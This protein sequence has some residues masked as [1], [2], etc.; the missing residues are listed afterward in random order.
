MEGKIDLSSQVCL[1]PV[2]MPMH[3]QNS[4]ISYFIFLYVFVARQSL[5]VEVS[6]CFNIF[7]SYSFFI[8]PSGWVLVVVVVS[9]RCFLEF[10]LQ[11]TLFPFSNSLK[12]FLLCCSLFQCLTLFFKLLL[13]SIPI[14]LSCLHLCWYILRLS[15]PFLICFWGK[16]FW[17]VERCPSIQA[18]TWSVSSDFETSFPAAMICPTWNSFILAIYHHCTPQMIF[19][20]SRMGLNFFVW[21]SSMLRI[22]YL[23]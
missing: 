10:F 5:T 19:F 8:D 14:F 6:M 1:F 4:S 13:H 7:Y 2:V 18:V 16:H 21:S 23:V 9:P 17:Q 11:I 15:N 20:F 3:I 12:M 22:S